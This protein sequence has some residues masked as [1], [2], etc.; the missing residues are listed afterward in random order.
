V[1]IFKGGNNKMTTNNIWKPKHKV[2]FKKNDDDK[3]GEEW[4]ECEECGRH[5]EVKHNECPECRKMNYGYS[6]GAVTL[7][8]YKN[9]EK[10]WKKK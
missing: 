9:W 8:S 5:A 7:K 2:W 6:Q 3:L 4:G 10:N 1:I